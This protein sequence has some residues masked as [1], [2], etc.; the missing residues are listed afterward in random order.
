MRAVVQRVSRA[1]VTVDGETTGA[2]DAGL[3]VYLG[4]GPEDGEREV[5]WVTSKVA[6]LRVFPDEAGRFDRS[7]TD[8]AGSVLV[9]SQFTLYGDTRRG[10]RPSFTDAAP[11]EVA[12][13][14]V[15]RVMDA[16]RDRGLRVEG[17]R[18]G[19]HMLVDAVND[20][21][22]TILLDSA[23]LDRPRRD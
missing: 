21:P 23:D 18:F 5:A 16:I 22:V 8:I 7:V 2:I 20:G 12:A 17:G 14:L 3:L 15:D 10:R 19:A 11:P 4:I 6:D 9:V 13:P 1:R